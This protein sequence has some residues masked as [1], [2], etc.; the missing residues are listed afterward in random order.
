MA[1]SRASQ[2]RSTPGR[3]GE[4]TLLELIDLVYAAAEDAERWDVFLRRCGEVLRAPVS[5]I[6]FEDL[7]A[8]KAKI[9][10]IVG[11]DPALVRQYEQYYAGRNAW[12]EAGLPS[13]SVGQPVRSEMLLPDDVLLR[14]EYY[15][16]MLRPLG[17]RHLLAAFLFRSESAISQISFLRPHRVGECDER[18]TELFGSLIPHLQRAF[19]LHRRLVE[20]KSEHE[21]AVEALDR[22][23]V[24]VLLLDGTGKALLV[25]RSAREILSGKDGLSLQNDGLH[26]GRPAETAALRRLLSDALQTG[27]GKGVGSGGVLSISRPSLRRPYSVFVTPLRAERSAFGESGAVAAVFLSDPEKKPETNPEALKRLYGFTPAE[28]RIAERLLRGESIEEAA[29]DLHVS[30]NTARTHVKSLF[31]KTDTHRHRELLRILLSGVA[32]IRTA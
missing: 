1:P 30:I 11:M 15:D 27:A 20:L 28:A 9:A 19:Q 32:T 21:L 6:I 22:V 7:R 10:R 13:V 18:E 23:P 4:G 17:A 16:G 29:Q 24:G 26:A 12:I 2:R 25:N 31:D 8:H 14:T 3:L 5:A